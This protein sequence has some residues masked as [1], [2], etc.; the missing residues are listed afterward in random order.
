VEMKTAGNMSSAVIMMPR[1]RRLDWQR[2]QAF[3]LRLP[4]SKIERT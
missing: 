4:T 1:H 3:N 2:T